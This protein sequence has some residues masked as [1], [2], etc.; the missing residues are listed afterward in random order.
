[1]VRTVLRR[2][3]MAGKGKRNPEPKCGGKYTS[4]ERRGRTPSPCC[5]ERIG[6]E[7][8]E[9][10]SGTSVF[11]P[12]DGWGNCVASNNGGDV[13]VD[14]AT[15]E[16]GLATEFVAY[17]FRGMASLWAMNGW[18]SEARRGRERLQLDLSD[19]NLGYRRSMV[20]GRQLFFFSH[21]F[22]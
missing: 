16:R 1:M 12:R 15:D 17:V 18:D 13:T 7:G 19:S 5:G 8:G 6:G 10:C 2:M 14:F 22:R 9:P 4:G 11:T 21:A 3:A 20:V